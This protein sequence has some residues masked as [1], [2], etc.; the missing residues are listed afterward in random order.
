MG[1]KVAFVKRADASAA[2]SSLEA[3]WNPSD[4]LSA[5]ASANSDFSQGAAA[6]AANDACGLPSPMASGSGRAASSGGEE[7]GDGRKEFV[8]RE[9]SPPNVSLVRHEYR[10]GRPAML[11]VKK[12]IC[13]A[14]RAEREWEHLMSRCAHPNVLRY[15][16]AGKVTTTSKTVYIELADAG[17]IGHVV[18]R[19]P[20]APAAR[21]A[22]ARS[23]ARQVLSGLH[24]YL[25]VHGRYHRDVKPQNCLALRCGLVKVSD[26]DVSRR[27]LPQAAAEQYTSIGTL[28]YMAPEL[29]LRP[30][31]PNPEKCDIWSVA[32]TL[33]QLASGEA[34]APFVRFFRPGERGAPQAEHVAQLDWARVAGDPALEFLLRRCLVVDPSARMTLAEAAAATAVLVDSGGGGDGGV[35]GGAA[36]AAVW[37]GATAAAWPEAEARLAESLGVVLADA[38]FAANRC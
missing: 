9:L 22:A 16:K 4:G 3:T 29:V 6:A 19:I 20:S 27:V 38:A 5:A 26:F 31:D 11:L 33:W 23:V 18:S 10:D 35:A 13:D 34:D 37:G 21:A 8:V 32:A 1:P 7:I 25:V 2:G 36:A 14:T 15:V 28:P 30:F 12:T 17:E 24:Y